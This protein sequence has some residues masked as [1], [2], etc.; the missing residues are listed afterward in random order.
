MLVQC[1]N[2]R[3]NYKVSDS[4]LTTS[5]PTLR[6]SRCKHIFILGAKSEPAAD[7][8]TEKP[9]A[10]PEKP[11]ADSELSFSFPRSEQSEP[12][13]ESTV[14]PAEVPAEKQATPPPPPSAPDESP[15]RSID[16][17]RDDRPQFEESVNLRPSSDEDEETTAPE[18]PNHPGQGRLIPT[19]LFGSLLAVLVVVYALLALTHQTNPERLESFL[20]AIPGL[21]QTIFRNNHLQR[22]I[23]LK[24][25]APSF[26]TIRGNREI[27][28][29]SG[30][31]VNQN[32]LAVREV[33]IEGAVYDAEGKEMERQ[34]I[35]VGNPISLKIIKAIT[36]QDIST[37]QKLRPP[38]RFEISPQQSAAFIIVFLKPTREIKSF[39]YRVVSAEG[40]T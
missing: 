11:E 17:V 8:E 14:D 9:L 24:S 1:P 34:A 32:P 39:H 21:G 26:Q 37:L 10:S 22:G 35:T 36:A 31:A 12:L 3:T 25:V 6:C 23:A 33:R 20:R 28:I 13:E 19:V 4:L 27:F 15:V 16:S 2:C 29:I 30:S 5:S 38:H 18:P 40:T 7:V